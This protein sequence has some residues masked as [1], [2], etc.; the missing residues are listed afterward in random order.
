MHATSDMVKCE[1]LKG[2]SPLAFLSTFDYTESHMAEFIVVHSIKV[3]TDFIPETFGRLTTVGPRF[4]LP[5][6]ARQHH[7]WFQVSKCICGY[8]T[9]VCCSQ[10]KSGNT[11]S[12]GCLKAVTTIERSTT[13]GRTNSPEYISWIAMR[14]RCQYVKAQNYKSYGGQG[15]SVYA[16]WN[17]ANG[18]FEQFYAHVGAKPTP[19]HEIDRY[20]D[21]DGNY[22][23]G[24]VR[25]ATRTEQN[26]N[27]K[28]N[29]NITFNG[30]T[31]CLAAWAE[32]LGICKS[33][34]H[35]RIKRGWATDSVLE[36]I[37]TKKQ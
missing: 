4:R 32:E 37:R 7:K 23:P 2:S 17:N 1:K 18:G 15:V 28:S 19:N 5:V 30:K 35:S 29:V 31:Q 25:W 27:R 3:A 13:H 6:N 16:D 10:L 8:F 11:K 20:P 33:T 34:L 26:R 24:N 36:P 22:E 14:Q 9:V 21:K 12:C